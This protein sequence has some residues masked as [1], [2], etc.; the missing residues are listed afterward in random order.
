VTARR[1]L[2]W[3]GAAALVVLL[4]RAVGYAAVPGPEAHVYAH[5]LGGPGLPAIAL[6]SLALGTALASA[7][8]W[9][10]AFGVRERRL[11]E[12]RVLASPAPTLTAGRVL[13]DAAALWALT[14]PASGLVESYVHWRSGL[15]WHGLECLVGPV[16][17]DLLP[18]LAALCL[19]AAAS[20]AA[21]GHVLAWMSRVF[22]LLAP[23]RPPLPPAPE[24][25]SPLDWL[26]PGEGLLPA[27]AGARA[28]PSRG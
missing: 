10:A 15:G 28:P 23:L 6:T 24:I 4:G 8:C 3:T 22:A 18:I 21:A 20:I 12:R 26:L 5:R 19:V 11:L 9:V 7:I 27:L 1:G 25:R 14:A 16:H 13:L 17:R 2:V